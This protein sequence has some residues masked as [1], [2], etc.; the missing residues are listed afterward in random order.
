M[1]SSPVS[2]NLTELMA[3]LGLPDSVVQMPDA[4]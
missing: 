3:D 4:E 2:S 1:R